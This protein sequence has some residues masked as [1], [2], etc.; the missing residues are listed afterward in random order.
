MGPTSRTFS[1][2]KTEI[3]YPLI[4]Q[5]HSP[6]PTPD[7]H[8]SIFCFYEF[9]HIRPYISGL[10]QYLSFCVWLFPLACLQ[11]LSIMCQ[12]CLPFYS[13][14]IFHCVYTCFVY[15]FIFQWTLEPW[16]TG[17]FPPL[18][19]V[20]NA[21]NMHVQVSLQDL[22]L[23]SLEH[24]YTEGGLLD[25]GITQFLIFWWTAIVFSTVAAPFYIP[26]N[27][28]QSSD[29]STSLPILVDNSHPNGGEVVSHYGFDLHFLND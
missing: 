3:L 27:N 18:T 26:S 8:Y 12:N 20:N 29:F 14:L 15:P 2:Y 21:M 6:F 4:N 5:P 24:I 28:T 10:I 11:G 7:N 19:I 17:L 16:N 25:H 23:R 9:D 1:F 22:A 13:W